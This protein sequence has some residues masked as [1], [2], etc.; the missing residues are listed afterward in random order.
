MI[1]VTPYLVKPVNANQ[2]VLPTDGYQAPTD[3]GRV[4]MGQLQSGDGR[5][6]PKPS[7]AAPSAAPGMSGAN[8]PA[9]PSG[10][11]LPSA[12]EEARA[13]PK[14]PAVAPGFSN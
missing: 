9:L 6:R 3:L 7:V 2:I 1:V 10:P 5:D 11:T 8:L 14:R 12:R 4:F 13:N